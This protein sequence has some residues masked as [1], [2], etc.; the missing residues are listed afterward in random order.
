M[1]IQLDGQH[2]KT[3]NLGTNEEKSEKDHGKNKRRITQFYTNKYALFR[4][5]MQSEQAREIN[6]PPK[7]K[8]KTKKN[9]FHRLLKYS[10]KYDVK[11]MK[12]QKTLIYMKMIYE[13]SAVSICNKRVCEQTTN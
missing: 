5:R 11:Y 3:N 4:V 7:K 6:P 2:N 9:L 8:R 13:K 1:N 12:F 10:I